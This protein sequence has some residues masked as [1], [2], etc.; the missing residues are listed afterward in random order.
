MA[1]YGPASA[2]LLVGGND[3]ST[4][5]YGLDENVEQIVEETRGLGAS[6]E[7]WKAA[8][9]ARVTL[10]AAPGLYTDAVF[11]QLA[12]YEQN[13]S[14]RKLVGY[15]LE[16]GALGAP[17]TM[18]DGAFAGIWKR[19]AKKEGLTL[20]GASFVISGQHYGPGAQDATGGARILGIKT[21]RSGDGDTESASLDQAD[22]APVQSIVDS[23]AD[24]SVQVVAHGLITGDTV[25][26]AGHDSTP[27]IDGDQTITVV[28]VDNFSVDG[29]DITVG[30]TAAGTI[31]K[32]SSTGVIVDLHIPALDLGGGTNV[33]VLVKDSADDAAWSTIATFAAA[34]S[35]AAGTSERI[36][37]AGHIE[38]YL[39]ITW[40]FTGGAAQT[41]T[42][43]VAVIRT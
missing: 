32:T 19:M 34:T 7:D 14:T 24:D 23:N 29:I 12:A 11:K 16:G 17:V 36:T 41:V 9:V 38:R 42:P 4:E 10:E 27:S 3:L 26:I 8:G 18:I 1:N 21:S 40:T 37:V 31:K 28:D 35:E 30:G 13:Q 33:V 22:H 15:G 20:A 2:F 43:Y 39:S 6:S 25:L 5:S